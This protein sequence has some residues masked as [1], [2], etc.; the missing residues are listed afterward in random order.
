[1]LSSFDG[2]ADAMNEDGNN[3][4]LETDSH[5]KIAVS[6]VKELEESLSEAM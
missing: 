4:A 5:Y 6:Q 2:V 3:P 1:M